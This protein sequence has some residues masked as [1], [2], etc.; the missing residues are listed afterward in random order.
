M[1]SIDVNNILLVQYRDEIYVNFYVQIGP[2]KQHKGSPFKDITNI[3]KVCSGEQ[4]DSKECKDDSKER[5]R[6]R[7]RERYAQLPRHRKQALLQ[8]HCEYRQ[9]KKAAATTMHHGCMVA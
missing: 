7:E 3:T 9:Q 5:K 1:I 4:A 2:P 6:Q 8:K